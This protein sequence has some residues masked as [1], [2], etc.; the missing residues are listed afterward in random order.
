MRVYWYTSI[1]CVEVV[2]VRW[3]LQ[4]VDS[5]WNG[6]LSCSGVQCLPDVIHL[7]CQYDVPCILKYILRYTLYIIVCMGTY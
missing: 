4:C 7:I 2:Y 1:Y 3:F 6:S 5:L